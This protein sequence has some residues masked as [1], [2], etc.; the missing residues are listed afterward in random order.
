VA[1]AVHD[2]ADGDVGQAAVSGTW[3]D[4]TSGTCE[5][6]D[7]GQC[8]VARS[9]IPAKV[10]SATFTVQDVS[11]ATLTYD[12]SANHDPPGEYPEIT[13]Y[14]EPP[15][16]MPPVAAFTHSCTDQTCVFDATGSYDPDGGTLSY[17]WDL[18]DGGA[19]AEAVVPHTY[20]DMGT[21]TVVLTVTDDGG[22]TDTDVQLVPVGGAVPTMHV[23]DLDGIGV[24][25]NKKFW[26]AT[27]T[28]LVQDQGRNP[29]A[30]ATVDGTWVGDVSGEGSCVTGINGLCT[31]TSPQILRTV[32]A[33][34][35]VSFVVSD[36]SHMTNVYL[37]SDDSDPDD[38]SDGKSIIVT[39]P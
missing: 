17:A 20:A 31:I 35:S 19:A 32:D 3:S 2:A 10:A 38:D 24:V 34:A 28:I 12:R 8:N 16:N 4:G 11:H 25:S 23:A 30:D 36:V 22:A 13:V 9:G 18:G 33:S 37:P 5:T 29:V 7:T 27:V 26:K 15:T 1:I 21:Y 14:L 39:E 6:D